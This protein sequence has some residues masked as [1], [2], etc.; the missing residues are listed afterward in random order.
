[1]RSSV[2]LTLNDRSICLER[3]LKRFAWTPVEPLQIHTEIG[4][5][6]PNETLRSLRMRSRVLLLVDAV[7]FALALFI[8]DQLWLSTI[9]SSLRGS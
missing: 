7:T 5:M 1:M 6:S 4:I 8:D 9:K 3:L 2:E